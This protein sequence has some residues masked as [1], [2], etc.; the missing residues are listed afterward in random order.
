MTDI[1]VAALPLDIV[2]ANPSANIGLMRRALDAIPPVDLAVVPELF[3]TGF[4]TDKA[5]I[6]A[7]AEPLDGPAMQAVRAEASRRDC[8]IC[9]TFAARMPDNTLRNRSFFVSPDGTAAF[10]DKHHL[11]SIS[12]EAKLFAPGRHPTPIMEY[13]G[14]KIAMA[15]CYDLRF[16]VWT[17]NTPDSDGILPYDI[18]VIPASWP[19]SRGFAWRTLLQARAIENQACIIGANRSGSDDFGQYDNLTYTVDHLGRLVGD[20]QPSGAVIA[21]FDRE[22]LIKYRKHFPVWRDADKFYFI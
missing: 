9:G 4:I 20:T 14:W 16:P 21:T 19:E 6:E 8:A 11:F 2:P 13:R 3:T 10:Y 15:I 5:A 1:T 12:D 7:W 22:K 17:R 18:L